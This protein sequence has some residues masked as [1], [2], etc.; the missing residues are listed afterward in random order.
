MQTTVAVTN[1]Y[2][3]IYVLHAHQ[4]WTCQNKKSGLDDSL[5]THKNQDDNL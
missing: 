2:M 3:C 1:K 5:Q 4:I